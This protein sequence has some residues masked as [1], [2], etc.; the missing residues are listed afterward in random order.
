MKQTLR[1]L[2]FMHGERF[3]H[4]DLKPQNIMMISDD[5]NSIKVIDFGLTEL[6]EAHQ[7]TSEVF[8]GTLLY[9]AP[10]V[11]DLQLS[12][13]SDIWSA[14]VILYNLITGWYPFIGQ[15]PL[16][17]GKNQSWWEE[18]TKRLIRSEAYQD[19]AKLA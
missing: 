10:E 18:E 3:L 13:K 14:G 11:L 7:K 2:A 12:M 19:H 9:M 1:A 5:S 6:F 16:P 4:K 15:W 17:P 8:G